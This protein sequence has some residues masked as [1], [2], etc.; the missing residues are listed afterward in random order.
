MLTHVLLT[1][2]R[3]SDFTFVCLTEILAFNDTHPDFVR[4][5][6]TVFGNVSSHTHTPATDR[7][8][9]LFLFAELSLSQLS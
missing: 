4:I 9:R 8:T 3:T 7:L 2:C 5:N 6:T 1:L